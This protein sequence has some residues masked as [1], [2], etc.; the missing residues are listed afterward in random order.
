MRVQILCDVDQTGVLIHVQIRV[1]TVVHIVQIGV[2]IDV[3]NLI[4]G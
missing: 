2:K 3:F 4:A 1:D